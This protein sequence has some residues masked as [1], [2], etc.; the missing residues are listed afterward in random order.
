MLHILSKFSAATHYS[1]PDVEDWRLN[2]CEELLV[3]TDENIKDIFGNTAS[4]Y[5]NVSAEPRIKH[6][7]Q[8]HGAFLRRYQVEKAPIA[9]SAS[10]TLHF[11]QDMG[12]EDEMHT[13]STGTDSS[14]LQAI[15]DVPTSNLA[16]EEDSRPKYKIAGAIQDWN[17]EKGFGFIRPQGGGEDIF[18]HCTDLIA[19]GQRALLTHGQKV[20]YAIGRGK[21]GR[22]CAIDVTNTDGSAIS[23]KVVVGNTAEKH[24]PI[25]SERKASQQSTTPNHHGEMAT[26]PDRPVSLPLVES[27][28]STPCVPPARMSSAPVRMFSDRKPLSSSKKGSF[29]Y[30]VKEEGGK[31]VALKLVEPPCPLIRP[32][33]QNP[34]VAFSPI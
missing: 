6:L 19:T 21:D 9:K 16:E 23:G 2:M 28:V 22:P 29:R 8:R 30:K 12:T 20:L 10:C 32:L 17:D 25:F 4:A 31:P 27:L 1:P 3:L 15:P 5:G 14:W 26:Q 24:S 11:A 13:S 34:N 33:P 7:F 18:L